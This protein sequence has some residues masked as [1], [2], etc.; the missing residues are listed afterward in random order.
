MFEN[1]IFQQQYLEIFTEQLILQ[2]FNN[3]P[4]LNPVNWHNV[5]VQ[6]RA[7]IQDVLELQQLRWT[8]LQYSLQCG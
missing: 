8:E 5:G 2:T 1:I 4:A 3:S 6:Q 7:L